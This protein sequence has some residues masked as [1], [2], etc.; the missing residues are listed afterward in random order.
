MTGWVTLACY[1]LA[2]FTWVLRTIIMNRYDSV[3]NSRRNLPVWLEMPM[4]ACFISLGYITVVHEYV[5]VST[6]QGQGQSFWGCGGP[7]GRRILWRPHFL[8]PTNKRYMPYPVPATPERG[9]AAVGAFD[10]GCWER[11]C[12]MPRQKIFCCSKIGRVSHQRKTRQGS[13]STLPRCSRGHRTIH[14]SV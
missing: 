13:D 10:P 14:K 9:S 2:M 11:K 8:F 3:F 7:W 12:A 1:R 4:P 5:G 6:P